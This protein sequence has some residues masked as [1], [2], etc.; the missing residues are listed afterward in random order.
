MSASAISMH[1]WAWAFRDSI[2]SQLEEIHPSARGWC[3]EYL[4]KMEIAIY[5]NDI[6]ELTR[7]LRL[8]QNKITEELEWAEDIARNAYDHT[9][10]PRFLR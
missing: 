10:I 8:V 5:H 3:Y 4:A 1:D 6:V 7:L 2:S 9:Y